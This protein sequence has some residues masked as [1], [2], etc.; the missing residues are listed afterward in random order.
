MLIHKTLQWVLCHNIAT[1][2]NK[3]SSLKQ[4]AVFT[5]GHYFT[6]EDYQ[7]KILPQFKQRAEQLP[8]AVPVTTKLLLGEFQ[9]RVMNLACPVCV[10][11]YLRVQQTQ[12]D[13]RAQ[14][15]KWEI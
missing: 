5:C 13:T 6:R 1:L 15:D 3:S 12:I 14:V 2:T 7:D 4:H 11:N 10:F 8:I 9:Q